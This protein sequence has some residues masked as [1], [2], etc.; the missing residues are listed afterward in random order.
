MTVN[1]A[2]GLDPA[3]SDAVA[4]ARKLSVCSPAEARRALAC[5]DFTSLNDDDT[6]EAIETLCARA[7][8]PAGPVAAVC[9]Y[10]A[11]V[12]TA[13]RALEGAP[14]A[15]A[16]V[17]NFPGGDDPEDA[18]VALT[19]AAVA[20][21]ADEIDVVLPL[22]ALLQGDNEPARAM[23]S[24]VRDAAGPERPVKTILEIS[25]MPDLTM[26][27]H[28][29]RLAIDAGTTFVKTST[30]KAGH[31]ATL[32]ACAVMLDAIRQSGKPGL[33]LKPSGGIRTAEA[34]AAFLLLADRIMGEGWAKPACFRLGASGVIDPLVAAAAGSGQTDETADKAAQKDGE[35]Y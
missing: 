3:L 19:R 1:A 24:A 21:G 13:K 6:D 9:V 31:G 28:A 5:L 8:T 32:E 30:G 27:G 33:G 35:G 23:V 29:A 25:R 10:P 12:A 17:V 15:V 11:F 2:A 16:T 14:I 7:M 34:A 4:A 26:V 20:D 22:A 18:V